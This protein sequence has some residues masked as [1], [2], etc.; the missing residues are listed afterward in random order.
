M[1]SLS[2][3][4]VNILRQFRTSPTLCAFHSNSTVLGALS[5]LSKHGLVES[6]STVDLGLPPRIEGSA[7]NPWLQSGEKIS[8]YR[9]TPLGAAELAGLK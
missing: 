8:V 6:E 7:H 5:A 2:Q 9:L 1:A 3:S 4:S